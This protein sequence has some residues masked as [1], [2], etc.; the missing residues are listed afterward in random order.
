MPVK[1][2]NNLSTIG[3]IKD[4]NPRTLP[5]EDQPGF[6]WSDVQNFRFKDGVV[7]KMNG[8]EQLI[9]ATSTIT[10]YYTTRISNGSQSFYVYCGL[11]KIYTYYANSH[12][13]IT[14]QSGAVDV[15]YSA[16]SSN[17]WNHCILNGFP[18]FNNGIDIPQT[19]NPINQSTR[20]NNLT[21][22]PTSYK[23]DVIRSYKA[24]L[25]AL[26]ITDAVPSVNVNKVKWSAA[27]LPGALPTTWDITDP[28][29]DAG[30][31]SL[32]DSEG[33]LVDCLTLNDYN[34]IYKSTSTYIMSYVGGNT[35][36]SIR[37]LF[38][39]IGMLSKNCAAYFEGKHFVV[40]NDDVII[41]DG[42]T[43]QSIIDGKN[44]KY[45]FN[46][47]SEI[48]LVELLSFQITVTQKCGYVSHQ[49][50]QHIQIIY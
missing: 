41:H 26:N 9:D 30:E 13:N 14:R 7:E 20:L 8:Y 34:I 2:F 4:Q 12:Y 32:S 29:N 39:N 35:V 17:Q 5:V 42:N 24:Y 25:I 44:K 28:T 1:S 43:Y 45:L 19:W 31:I 50:P 48:L 21:N 23:A 27:A 46:N 10:P 38:P 15:N 22:W 11:N 36:F 40:T 3:L 33:Y 16:S 47:I 49:V 18:I 6:A 37:K